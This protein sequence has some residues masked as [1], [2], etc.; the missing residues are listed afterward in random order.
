MPAKTVIQIRRDSSANWESINPILAS[1]EMGYDTT[2]NVVKIGNGSDN[3]VSLPVLSGGG[4]GGAQIAVSD[5]PPANPSQGD[6][7]FESDTTRKFIY[8]DSYWIEISA[9][10]AT[11]GN[12]DGGFPDSDYGGMTI[13]DAGII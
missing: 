11:I 12:L 7:W 6:M 5:D 4:S 13:I 2:N 10:V 8:Y 9:P 1:G 3:W